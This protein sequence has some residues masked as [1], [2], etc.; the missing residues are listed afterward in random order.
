MVQS[1]G[2]GVME[3]WAVTVA[4][5]AGTQRGLFSLLFG[6]GAMMILTRLAE[7]FPARE[8]AKIY[9][10]RIVILMIIGL[11]D[12]FIFMWPSDILFVY[13]LCGLLLFPIYKWRTWVVLLLAGVV[14][15]IP[16]INRSGDLQELQGMFQAY[17]V[18]IAKQTSAETLNETEHAAL[19]AWPEELADARPSLDDERIRAITDTMATGSFQEVFVNQARGTIIVQTIVNYHFYFLDALGVMLLGMVFFKLGIFTAKVSAYTLTMML[20][21]GF[22]IGLPIS[23]WKA[24]SIIASGFDPIAQARTWLLYDLGRVGM[25]VGY[26][27]TALL[28]CRVEWGRWLKCPLAAVGRMALTNYLAQSILGALIFYSFGLGW[29]G[30]IAGYQLYLVVVAIWIAQIAWSRAWLKYYCYGPVEW[31]WR[32]LTYKQPQKM[33]RLT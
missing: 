23:V 19:A 24:G 2:T 12:G 29:Y 11:I 28:F 10:R 20:V 18:A 26:L 8:A 22:A 21:A 7:R 3:T 15:A 31:I 33:R 16:M 17:E 9:Y 25:M 4:L 27:C 32:S 14:F 1:L 5:L 6:A 30:Q 13:G